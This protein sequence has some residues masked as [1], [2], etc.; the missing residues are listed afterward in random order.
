MYIQV[1]SKKFRI[2]EKFQIIRP[3]TRNLNICFSF[4]IS[5]KSSVIDIASEC[6]LKVHIM[7]VEFFKKL[8]KIQKRLKVRAFNSGQLIQF[9]FLHKRK[10]G[11]HFFVNYIFQKIPI[12]M[13]RSYITPHCMITVSRIY[14][15]AAS[16]SYRAFNYLLSYYQRI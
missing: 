5:M 6:I 10:S 7:L 9:F 13:Q 15:R 1:A 12:A 11:K 3:S 4:Q 16:L 2:L 8:E 14:L